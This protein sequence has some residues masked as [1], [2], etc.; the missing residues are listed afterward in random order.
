MFHKKQTC[1]DMSAYHR[2]LETLALSPRSVI[3]P[4]QIDQIKNA[5]LNQLRLC[6]NSLHTLYMLNLVISSSYARMLTIRISQFKLNS[7]S[8]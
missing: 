6:G 8:S 3:S 5:S 2:S 4:K 7:I 1:K